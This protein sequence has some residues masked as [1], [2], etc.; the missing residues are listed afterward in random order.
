MFCTVKPTIAVN[1]V[2]G[3]HGS[4]V[5]MPLP[6]TLTSLPAQEFVLRSLAQ[7]MDGTKAAA[8]KSAGSIS[9]GIDQGRLRKRLRFPV[10]CRLIIL[11]KLS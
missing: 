11:S 7:A 1:V 9:K 2:P 4:F 6:S 10:V 5:T 8:P 3:A